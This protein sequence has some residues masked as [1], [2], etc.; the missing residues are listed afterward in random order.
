MPTYDYEC[1]GC[2]HRFEE[3]QAITAKP[4][5]KCPECKKAKLLRLIGAG[6]GLIF[7]GAGFYAT[8]NRSASYQAGA[9]ADRP[10]TGGCGMD[11]KTGVC[12]KPACKQ[13]KTPKS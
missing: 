7:K 13:G 2:G 11:P 3:F 6:A 4:L 10:D 9:K 8:D 1:Q 12:G 5:K